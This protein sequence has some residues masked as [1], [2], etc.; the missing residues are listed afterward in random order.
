MAGLKLM[1]QGG[2]VPRVAAHLLQDNEAQR[3]VNTKLY[4]GDLRSWYKPS[5]VQPFFEVPVNTEAIYRGKDT[6]GNELWLTW[7]NEVDV[8]RNPITDSSNPMSIYYTGDGTP[9]KTNSTLAGS[10]QGQP[11]ADY[12]NMGVAAPGTKPTVTRV[13]SGGS[14][15]T[16]VY[17]Y[18]HI[19]EFGGI[20][21]ESAPSPVSDEVLCGTGDTITVSGFVTPPTSHYNITKRRI[22]RS[23]TGSAAT[24]FLFVAEIA[25]ATTSYSDNVAASALGEE[26]QSL[27]WD[28]PPS[29]LTS[30]VAHPSGF[31][32]GFSQREI[33]MSEVNAP[34]AWPL[35][36]R[37]SVNYDIVGLGI[38]GTSVAVMTKGYP[39]IVTG[40]TPESMSPEQIP[41]L[42]PCVAK[43]SIA[44]DAAGVMY[45]SP[46]GLCLIGPSGAGLATGNIMLRDNFQKFNPL[47]LRSVIYAGKYFGFYQDGTEYL[48]NGGFIL[49]RSIPA[50]P[51]SLMSLTA[52]ACYVEP[53]TADMYFLSMN[54]I[55]K[56]EGDQYNQFPFEWLS[57]RFVFTYPINLGALEVDAD[58]NSIQAAAELQQLIAEIIAENQA[59]FSSGD[60]LQGEIN[61]KA[62]N[63]FELNGSIL[64]DIPSAVD[65]RYVQVSVYSDDV[66]VH[67]AVYTQT[68]VYRMP[69]GY[70][71]QNFEVKL[72]GNIELRYVKMAETVKELKTL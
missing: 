12:L 67:N 60:D 4:A 9:K 52:D 53:E 17:V 54:R 44:S 69:A 1:T 11:P 39:Q 49:D 13:G 56:W 32:I 14:P 57:K 51:L 37:I 6:G 41:E 26:L 31:L 18:T 10:T 36:Y 20:E 50:S 72:A 70:K 68:G 40:L 45:A 2:Y 8:A 47:T 38:F 30:I 61:D 27:G 16:R 59:I 48:K 46:N 58:F 23:V 63:H 34:H 33:C 25:V 24:T 66:L 28:E 62:L 42:E 7:L 3:A 21:E 15:E 64:Q 65:D 43:R 35:A 71:G 5:Y 22:Y 29:D 55:Q 19:Q